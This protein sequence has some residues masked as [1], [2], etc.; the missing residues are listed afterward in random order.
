[1]EHLVVSASSPDP[2]SIARAAASLRAGALVAFPTETVYGLGAKARDVAALRRLYE[3]KGRPAYNPVIVH[4]ADAAA[5]REL[6]DG[7]PPAAERLAARYW[8]G[9]L[10]LVLPRSA[11][12]PDVVTAG[13]PS[14]GIRVPAHPVALALLRAAGVPVAAP[15]ANRSTE[16]SPTCAEHVARGLGDRVD[17]LLDGGETE[18]GIE[19]TVV[20]L[21]GELP[22]LLRPGVLTREELELVVGPIALARP[23]VGT[24]A[25]RA[26]GQLARHYAPRGELELLPAVELRERLALARDASA[27]VGVLARTARIEPAPGI[28]VLRMPMAPRLYARR[29][30]AALHECD[31]A[32][33]R[34]ILVETVP[35]DPAWEGVRDR[36]AR[37]THR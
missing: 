36:L 30:Y 6:C 22:V 5:A 18:L 27:T 11:A 10:T 23:G 13:L 12:V 21:T 14:V 33:C 37:A 9:P 34:R 3:A 2:A 8:P 19:S 20:D 28:L 31:A 35:D 1:M 4:V 7:W 15:S 25:R 17:V 24:E 16:L 29:L 26:P 32:G